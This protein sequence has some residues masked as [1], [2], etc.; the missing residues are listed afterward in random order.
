MSPQPDP[1]PLLSVHGETYDAATDI[2]TFTVKCE[3][4]HHIWT[5][6]SFWADVVD[7]SLNERA[8]LQEPATQPPP[9]GRKGKRFVIRHA[10]GYGS[11][12]WEF[13][14][15]VRGKEKVRMQVNALERDGFHELVDVNRKLEGSQLK[16]GKTW[17][18][19]ERWGSATILERVE[20][21]V[22][23]WS[24]GLFVGV[25]VSEIDV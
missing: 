23:V 8:Y 17:T 3:A 22:P 2:R 12:L 13:T 19:S 15:S 7:W 20:K 24:S 5:V 4:P 6:F 1:A 14:L 16:V 21:V 18:W 10:G 11:H 9:P 25:V